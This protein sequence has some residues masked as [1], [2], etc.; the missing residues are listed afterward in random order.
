[1]TC[2]VDFHDW[3]AVLAEAAAERASCC[4]AETARWM[5]VSVVDFVTRIGTVE[6]LVMTEPLIQSGTV[7]DV[8]IGMVKWVVSVR[9]RNHTQLY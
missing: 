1:M 7:E 9:G 6:V 2:D 3:K 4:V 8:M 5:M